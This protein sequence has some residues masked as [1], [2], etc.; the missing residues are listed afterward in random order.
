MVCKECGSTS[1]RLSRLLTTDVLRMLRFQY[2]VRCRGCSTRIFVNSLQALAIRFAPNFR[3]K[4]RR[5]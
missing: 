4:R 3:F 2:P 5:R 1:F